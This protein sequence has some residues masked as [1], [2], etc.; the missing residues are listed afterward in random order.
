M[1]MAGDRDALR[2][3]RMVEARVR[4]V[5]VCFFADFVMQAHFCILPRQQ[6]VVIPRKVCLM[7]TRS[8]SFKCV[9][10]SGICAF[11]AQP[12]DDHLA[13]NCVICIFGPIICSVYRRAQ[14]SASCRI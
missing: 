6:H 2:E 10:A 12:T 11:P 8:M 5:T 4:G 14:L 7:P 9:T 1:L 3:G 13:L